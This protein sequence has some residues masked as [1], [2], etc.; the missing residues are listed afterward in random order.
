M[1]LHTWTA[2]DKNLYDRAELVCRGFRLDLV[3]I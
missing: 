1:S 2:A 3:E